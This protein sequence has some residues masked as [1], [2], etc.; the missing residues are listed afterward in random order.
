MNTGLVRRAAPLVVA[1][2]LF[3][4]LPGAAASAAVTVAGTT[5]V[6]A[7][8][9]ASIAVRLPRPVRFA[10]YGDVTFSA[11]RGRVT[12]MVLKKD[13]DWDAPVVKAVHT[14]FCPARGCSSPVPQSMHGS[15]WAPGTKDGVE[16]RLP[17][18]SYRLYVVPDGAPVTVTLRFSGLSGTRR[19]TARTPARAT[20]VAPAP[21]VAEP[22]TAPA[23]FAG[24]STFRTGP[25]GG[26][27]AVA[28]WKELPVFGEPG[29]VGVCEYRAAP[30]AGAAPPYQF[31][32]AGGSGDIPP[33]TAATF[34]GSGATTPIGPGRFLAS[35]NAGYLLAPDEQF[36]IG[37]YHNTVGPVTAAYVHQL[38]LDF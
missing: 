32:C 20:V 18:G 25:R 15:V 4:G 7:D 24:G 22:A 29:A 13:G 21:T 3:G 9:P 19:L 33:S 11:P 34:H 14:G 35:I 17:A 30:P 31:P 27:H 2:A 1:A 16:G 23:L 28:I 12:A 8:R 10:V 37:G 36:A 38:W 6:T 5:V 26:A